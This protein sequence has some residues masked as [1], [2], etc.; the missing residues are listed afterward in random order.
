MHACTRGHYRASI[1]VP[2]ILVVV[3]LLLQEIRG[4]ATVTTKL[5]EVLLCFPALDSAECVHIT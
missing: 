4:L 5:I 2:V 3:V 1:S